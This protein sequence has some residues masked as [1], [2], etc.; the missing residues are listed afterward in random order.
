[1][2][3]VNFRRLKHNIDDR[4]PESHL[5]QPMNTRLIVLLLL[6]CIV[7]GLGTG[8]GVVVS[9]E[10]ER[11]KIKIRKVRRVKRPKF[12]ERDWD[13]IYFKDLFQEGLVGTRPS[14][15]KAPEVAVTPTAPDRTTEEVPTGT[16]S[17]LVPAFIVED[18]IKKLQRSLETQVTTPV[19]FKSSYAEARQSYSMLSLLFGV[20]REYDEDIRWKRAAN[21]AQVA[22]A[23]TAANARVGT[24]QAYQSAKSRKESLAELIRGGKFNANEEIP[25]ELQWDQVVDRSPTMVRLQESLDLLKPMLSTKGEFTKNVETIEHE[26]S[27][28]AVIAEVLTREAMDDWE[29]DDYVAY[30]GEMKASALQ[31]A[32]GARNSNFDVASPAFNKIGQSCSN[33]HEE[34][35]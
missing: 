1:M 35:R 33:C 11:Q 34:W 25:S 14:M 26:A 4:K 22:F 29:E 2:K 23:R 7:T 17:K 18:E 31:L 30:A 32:T 20:V 3:L 5:R 27:L 13:G 21:L 8:L 15:I 24:Q 12:T 19:K 28:I 9:Q 6:T 10:G 16:W